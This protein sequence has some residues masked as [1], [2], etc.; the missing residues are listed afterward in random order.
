MR[1]LITSAGLPASPPILDPAC[2]SPLWPDRRRRWWGETDPPDTNAIVNSFPKPG[3]SPPGVFS[4]LF[5]S[6]YTPKRVV[7]Y[8]AADTRQHCFPMTSRAIVTYLVAAN[9]PRATHRTS[10]VAAS[11]GKGQ[12]RHTPRYRSPAPLHV[13]GSSPASPSY[14]AALSVCPGSAT[15]PALGQFPGA[16]F[17]STSIVP[18]LIR[19]LNLL[20]PHARGEGEG[21]YSGCVNTAA[22]HDA[23]PPSQN[24]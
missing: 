5:I 10:L 15:E 13:S 7:E 12:R 11:E 21:A 17:C 20:A 24:G 9:S 14:S 3:F 19:S 6:S 2:Q 4:W 22:M 23:L 18:T 1:T 8:V 16:P